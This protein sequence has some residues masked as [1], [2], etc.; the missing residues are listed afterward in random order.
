MCIRDRG[1]TAPVGGKAVAD[2]RGR[3]APQLPLPAGPVHPAGGAGHVVLGRVGEDLQLFQQLHFL[4]PPHSKINI[5]SFLFYPSSPQKSTAPRQNGPATFFL[6]LLLLEGTASRPLP[7]KNRNQTGA[8]EGESSPFELRET[9]KT[10]GSP[11]LLRHSLP[12]PHLRRRQE[13]NSPFSFFTNASRPPSAQLVVLQM[14]AKPPILKLQ[15]EALIWFATGKRPLLAARKPVH[16]FL[17][18]IRSASWSSQM[19]IRDSSRAA[20]TDGRKIF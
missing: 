17:C 13:K 14:R 4:C 10:G 16:G 1:D 15:P 11:S 19:C 18:V 7:A 3:R 12:A 6:P 5:C 8:R 20:R 9:D 2:A